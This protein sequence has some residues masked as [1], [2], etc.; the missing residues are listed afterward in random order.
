MEYRGQNLF[1][2]MLICYIALRTGPVFSLL[3]FFYASYEWC[4]M[5]TQG[6]RVMLSKAFWGGLFMAAVLEGTALLYGIKSGELGGVSYVGGKRLWTGD[7]PELYFLGVL[8]GVVLAAFL[9]YLKKE[10]RG[11]F[12]LMCI[13]FLWSSGYTK[14]SKNMRAFFLAQVRREG[15]IWEDIR[16]IQPPQSDGNLYIID[17]N[18]EIGSSSAEMESIC[19]LLYK[20]VPFQVE[21]LEEPD[22]GNYR[23]P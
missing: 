3:P 21:I 11:I 14:A 7:I 15:I 6:K 17:Q 19:R 2:A 1:L 13:M 22:P 4:L 9:R 12:I 10:K 23:R 18:G 5:R 20:N 8:G 16:Q